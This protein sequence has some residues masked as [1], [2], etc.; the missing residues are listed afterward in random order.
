MY[1]EWKKVCQLVAQRLLMYFLRPF[2]KGLATD[3]KVLEYQFTMWMNKISV[4]YF[5]Y[6][7]YTLHV[8]YL[9]QFVLSILLL[10]GFLRTTRLNFTLLKLEY[11]ILSHNKKG[12]FS[13]EDSQKVSKAQSWNTICHS[14]FFAIHSGLLISLGFLFL[15]TKWTISSWQLVHCMLDPLRRIT[16]IFLN[17]HLNFQIWAIWWIVK[18]WNLN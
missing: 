6:S 11:E 10:K 14:I 1:G 16:S 9:H 5:L 18:A 13:C 4:R 2:P 8:F 17:W 7:L 15:V 3:W 12:K